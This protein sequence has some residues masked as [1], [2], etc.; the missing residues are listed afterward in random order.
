MVA[1]LVALYFLGAVIVYILGK[2]SKKLAAWLT[3]AIA[4]YG[5]YLFYGINKAG[6]FSETHRLIGN[7][8][9]SFGIGPLS[10]FFGMMALGL[11]AV[12]VLAIT[13]WDDNTPTLMFLML[14]VLGAMSL[15][16][17]SRDFVSFFLAWE[18]MTWSSFATLFLGRGIERRVAVTRYLIWSVIGA[19]FLLLAFGMIYAKTGTTLFTVAVER[20][21]AVPFWWLFTV[22]I[23]LVIGFGVKA[24]VMP[25]HTWAPYAYPESPDTFTPIF[26]GLLSKMGVY[27]FFLAIF[28]FSL[29]FADY[30]VAKL[31]GVN[32][33]GYILAWFGAITAFGGALLAVKQ[34][35]AKKLL[36][37]SSVSQLGYVIF[38]LALG[39]SLGVTG[40]IYHALSHAVFKG[41]LFLAV[42]GVIMRAGTDD[43]DELGGLIFKMPLTFIFALIGILALAGIPPTIGFPSKWLLYEAG[44]E[45]HF[46]FIT[47]VIFAASTAAFLY[48]YRFLFSIFLGQLHDEHRDVKE[49]PL[50][51]I[52]SYLVLGG[53]GVYWG[54]FPGK[55]LPLIENI[56]LKFNLPALKT[57]TLSSITT[58]LGTFNATTVGILF[59]IAFVIGLIIFFLTGKRNQVDQLNN[60]FA[61]EAVDQIEMHYS[62][63]FYYFL[64]RE[65]K[66]IYRTS[67]ETVY[68]WFSDFTVWFGDGVRKLFAGNAQVY[69]FYFATFLALLILIYW[70]F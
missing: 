45:R 28:F 62:T 32:V 21:A 67:A 5:A 48:S 53:L 24:A 9:F 65:L 11:G 70:G 41:L 22:V 49:V 56:A 19:Y 2:L 31:S 30:D 68:K 4:A 64:E 61:G 14:T 6:G 36:A 20:M 15:I 23:F 12:F 40:A 39:T 57:Y 43:L 25:L 55:V 44:I 35:R 16:T 54:L 3:F 34:K 52:I 59:G 50:T 47:A 13:S 63:N 37:Y 29:K 66:P 51:F 8:G 1:K 18:I 27:G 26:S 58:S 38:G 10:Y 17:L 60:F 46:V 69:L 33:I 7:F 42:A